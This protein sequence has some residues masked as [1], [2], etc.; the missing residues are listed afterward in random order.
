MSEEF[1][2]FGVRKD[3]RGE[4]RKAGSGTGRSGLSPRPVGRPPRYGHGS[5]LSR[6]NKA[7]AKAHASRG[8]NRYSKPPLPGPSSPSIDPL[9]RLIASRPATK[10]KTGRYNAR[11]RRR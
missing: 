8:T 6:V 3:G 10:P 7:V 11:G 1:D 9:D 4:P 5:F 2:L